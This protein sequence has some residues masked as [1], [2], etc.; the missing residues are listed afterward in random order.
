MTE[1]FK[2]SLEKGKK[3]EHVIMDR[4]SKITKVNDLT[5]YTKHKTYQQK[6]IDFQFFNRKKEVWENADA[7]SNIRESDLAMLE[8]YKP[9]GTEGWFWK[10]KSDWIFHYNPS[11]SDVYYYDLDKMRIFIKNR[12]DNNTLKCSQGVDGAY[13]TWINL[14]DMRKKFNFLVKKLDKN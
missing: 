4:L 2:L 6:G 3:G 1:K 13:G 7:K 12:L 14:K 5:N 8:L 11:N 9:N 10:S